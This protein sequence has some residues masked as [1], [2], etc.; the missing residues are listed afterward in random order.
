MKRSS[1]LGVALFASTFLASL[2]DAQAATECQAEIVKGRAVHWTYRLIDGRKCWY[3][4]KTQ[5]PKSE[6]FWSDREEPAAAANPPA[7][8]AQSTNAQASPSAA[9]RRSSS[10][11]RMD[12]A[13]G[14]L[15]RKT[16]LLK[17]A[18]TV[19]NGSRELKS[20]A[21]N[22]DRRT[23]RRRCAYS[24]ILRTS[25]WTV[26]CAQ[27]HRTSMGKIARVLEYRR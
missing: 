24:K 2:N 7:T 10:I 25:I 17:R 14:R 26:T 8:N 23:A 27:H 21:G 15:R 22:R 9:E 11:P 4:G 12:R 18:G 19:S 3:E 16:K 6:L 13:A 5:L 1:I 20:K